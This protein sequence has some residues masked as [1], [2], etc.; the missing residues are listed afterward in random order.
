MMPSTP[1]ATKCQ[2]LGC[3]HTRSKL[4][5]FC[6]EHGGVDVMEYRESDS[7]YSTPMWRTIRQ[8]QLSRQPL[9]QSCLLRGH[10]EQAKHVDHVF[11]WKP[12]GRQAFTRNLMQSLCHECH[13]Y[14]TGQEKHGN[15]L[16]FTRDKML[17]YK[18]NE[19]ETTM[20]LYGS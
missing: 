14:K 12:I 5:S 8:G 18:L 2:H 19:Y 20:S 13:S 9:C 3:K 1:K 15:C 17:S 10:I 16:H 7:I 4:N 6:L 11:P